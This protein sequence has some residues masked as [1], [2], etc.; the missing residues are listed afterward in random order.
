M[1]KRVTRPFTKYTDTV[2]KNA[3]CDLEEELIYSLLIPAIN[4]M[5]LKFRNGNNLYKGLLE[6]LVTIMETD[7]PVSIFE[8]FDFG[9]RKKTGLFENSSIGND[10]RMIIK[11]KT[12]TD[13]NE[14]TFL[15]CSAA[16]PGNHFLNFWKYLQVPVSRL[17]GLISLQSVTGK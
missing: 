11:L 9:I 1:R 7:Y 15:F 16:L 8:R 5:I 4:E 2:A 13:S 17:P 10:I 6:I 14:R 3:G 12:K